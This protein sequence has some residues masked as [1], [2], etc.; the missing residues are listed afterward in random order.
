MDSVIRK[1]NKKPF[2]SF[3]FLP[4]TKFAI[5]FSICWRFFLRWNE[6]WS[7]VLGWER[8]EDISGMS[9]ENPWG[10]KQGLCNVLA[11]L[12]STNHHTQATCETFFLSR[13]VKMLSYTGTTTPSI[14]QGKM[15]TTS[16][17]RGTWTGPWDRKTS[18]LNLHTNIALTTIRGWA[19]SLSVNWVLPG[20]VLTRVN[21][22][23]PEST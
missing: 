6:S 10:W 23:T 21:M 13:A 5:S 20:S 22:T 3:L 8:Q 7:F 2:L 11:L 19:D 9:P 4:P 14:K 1:K 17:Q 18:C 12:Y 15:R 16:D